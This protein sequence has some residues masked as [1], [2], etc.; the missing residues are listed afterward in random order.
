MLSRRNLLRAAPG[1][2][3]TTVVANGVLPGGA[4]IPLVS[5]DP[6]E[7]STEAPAFT[8]VSM[9]DFFNGDVGDLS[10]LPSWDGGLNSINAS[11]EAAID[12]ALGAVSGHKPDAV[13]V[14]GDMVEGR[15]NIDSDNRR[16]FGAVSQGIDPLSIAQCETAISN[17]GRVYYGYYKNLFDQRGLT[18]YPCIGDHEILDDR[19]GALNSRWPT[20]GYHRGTPDNRYYLVDHAKDVWASH[21]TR[22]PTGRPRFA[23]RPV[24]TPAEFTAYRVDLGTN[25][26][27]V[28]VDMF[29]RNSQGVRLGVFADQLRWLRAEI[30]A[31]KRM[32][33]VV[34]VQGHLPTMVPYRKWYSGDLRLPEGRRSSFYQAVTA[35]GAD[36]LFTGEVHD[37]TVVQRGA[38]APVQIS[39]GCIFRYAFNYLVGN[40]HRDGTVS[41]DYY[42][43]PLLRASAD[44]SIWSSDAEKRQRTELEYGDPVRRG[45]LVVKDHRIVKRTEKLGEY[46]ATT[47]TYSYAQ[48]SPT[49]LY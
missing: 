34:I 21:W 49:V 15:W 20:G 7:A 11:W 13:F 9:P 26:T 38:T 48:T 31:A 1:P 2:G 44:K 32:G 16:L 17:A 42:E 46:E 36:F 43:M 40:V 12:K 4:T 25:L 6:A 47:D 10:A 28:T 37:T 33:R 35:A 39:H 24:G 29:D 22:T 23:R 18:V 5:T 3:A 41:I 14:A 8:F 27:L 45:S 19:A 30:T